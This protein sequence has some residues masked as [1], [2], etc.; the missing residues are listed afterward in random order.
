MVA[1][2]KIASV[3]EKLLDNT[4]TGGEKWTL[5]ISTKHQVFR[6]NLLKISILFSVHFKTLV[7]PLKKKAQI[8]SYIVDKFKGFTKQYLVDTSKIH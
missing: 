4:F 5:V 7:A 1:G 3:I 2:Q 8:Y 6:L